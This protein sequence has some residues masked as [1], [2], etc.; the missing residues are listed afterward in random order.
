MRQCVVG[1]LAS[2]SDLKRCCTLAWKCWL[3]ALVCSLARRRICRQGS[4]GPSS[5]MLAI[6][7]WLVRPLKRAVMSGEVLARVDGLGDGLA[8]ATKSVCG[9]VLDVDG[10][11]RSSCRS[12]RV[13]PV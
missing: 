3:S 9:G 11:S 1:C 10:L 13:E 6:L 4:S 2:L 12:G 7:G 5:M 8:N